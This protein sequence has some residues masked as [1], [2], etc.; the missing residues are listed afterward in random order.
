[1]SEFELGAWRERLPEWSREELSS[2]ERAELEHAIEL[3]PELREEAE[4]IRRIRSSRPEPPANLAARINAR[5]DAERPRH[6]R[7]WIP[8]GWRLSTAA[9]LVLAVGTSIIWRNQ[10]R[11]VPGVSS[12]DLI[13]P[14]T[15]S[16]LLDDGVI[17]GGA[18]LE[19]LSDEQL[20][21]LLDDLGV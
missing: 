15:E 8:G 21:S 5:L 3:D 11:S 20:S 16:W 12:V 6:G 14:V 17:A 10:G 7:G 2:E 13:D 9:V 4:L 18:V 19:D 1:M